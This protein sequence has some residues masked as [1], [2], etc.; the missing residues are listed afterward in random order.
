MWNGEEEDEMSNKT[1][2][3]NWT[4]NIIITMTCLEIRQKQCRQRLFQMGSHSTK[5]QKNLF[6]VKWQFYCLSG[7]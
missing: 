1:G 6:M 2:Q 7:I 3:K 4:P 5:D